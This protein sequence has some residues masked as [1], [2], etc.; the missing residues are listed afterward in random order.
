MEV[1]SVEDFEKLKKLPFFRGV[2]K[3]DSMEPLIKVGEKIVVEVGRETLERFDVIVVWYKGQLTCHFLWAK[4]VR[5]SPVLLQTMSL[6]FLDKD[7]PIPME[8][9]LGK[10]VSHRLSFFHKLRILFHQLR[11]R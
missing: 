10:V 5:V 8:A 3:S 6:K 4:N 7:Y 1:A 2:I 9:Y 11:S